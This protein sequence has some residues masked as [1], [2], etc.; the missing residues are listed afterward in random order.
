MG[1]DHVGALAATV[2]ATLVA[3]YLL[4]AERIRGG[5]GTVAKLVAGLL[6]A[7]LLGNEIAGHVFRMRFVG[8]NAATDLPLHMCDLAL[9]IGVGLLASLA[10]A[11]HWPTPD[12]VGRPR[13]YAYELVY[14]W[15]LAG[16]VQALLT[17]DL[18]FGWP[19]FQYCEFF[20]GHGGVV[21]SALILTLGYGMRPARGGVLRV[22]LATLAAALIIGLADALLGANYMYLCRKPGK[23]SLLDWLGAWP[24]Y[25]GS[26][27]LLAG[28]LYTVLDVPFWYA[29][30]RNR[31]TA[32]AHAGA[33]PI[34]LQSDAAQD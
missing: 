7:L 31:R 16:T 5:P 19:S 30:G 26:L 21:A 28:F 10:F 29:R 18:R 4:R 14:F 12:R 20:L 8:W 34:Q 11:R 33:A 6:G 2:G 22:W 3:S 25:I 9:L 1:P 13:Q 32:S 17:P 24:Y 23:D 15:G 27:G